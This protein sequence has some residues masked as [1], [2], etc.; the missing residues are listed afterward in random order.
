MQRRHVMLAAVFVSVVVNYLDRTNMA[1]AAVEL[2]HDLGLSQIELGLVFS[3]FAWSYSLLQIPGGILVDRISPRILYPILLAG[4]SIATIVQGFAS[5]LLLL[6]ICRVF[7]GIFE[8]PSFPINNRVATSW[9]PEQERAGAIGSYTAGQFL[10]LAVLAPIL[11]WVQQLWG[12]RVLFFVCGFA[13]LLWA[14]AWHVIYRDPLDDSK[15]TDSELALLREGKAAVEWQPRRNKAEGRMGRHQFPL[16]LFHRKLVGLYIGQFCIGSVSIFFLT[17]FPTYLVESRGVALDRAGWMTA[18]PFLAAMGGVVFAG[19]LSDAMIRKG[20]SASVAR[21]LPVL[22]GLALS[23]VILLAA[24][25]RSDEEALAAMSIA[26]FGNGMASI[27]WVFVSLLAPEGR[28]G[29]AGGIFNFCG[30]LSA[31]VT[32]LVIGA[33]LSTNDFTYVLVY[34]ATMAVVGMAA[35][36]VLIGKVERVSAESGQ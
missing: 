15:L 36:L 20:Y 10:G 2:R 19:R 25:A 23:S 8:A 24:F 29:L 7:V 31:I 18:L 6:L 21:K 1:V 4:W 33:L 9:F 14:W 26:F 30:G 13:G 11:F 28:V 27:A 12:W 32:P 16:A 34:M 3:A 17:W 35:Y 22:C 5:S